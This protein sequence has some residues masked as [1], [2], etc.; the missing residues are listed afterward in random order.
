M[1]RAE[2][3]VRKAVTAPRPELLVVVDNLGAL[4]A[5]H[6]KDMAGM[7]VIDDLARVYADGPA[8]GIRFAASADRTGSVPGPWAALTQQKLL[9]RLADPTEYGYF[10]VPR[11]AVPAFLPGRGIVAGS[12]QVLQ[13]RWYGEDLAA[14][15]AEV[16]AQW[17]KLPRSAP[18]VTALPSRITVA[19]LGAAARVHDDPMW[20]PIGLDDESLQ[21]VGIQLYEQE[22]ALIGGPP[23]SGRSTALCTVAT[24]L[25]AADPALH[26]IGVAVRRSPLREHRGLSAVTTEYAVL[27][28]LIADCGDQPLVL[29]VDDAESVDDPAGVIDQLLRKRRPGTTRHRRRPYRCPS[30]LVRAL[31]PD[32]AGQPQRTVAH[33]GRRPGR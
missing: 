25:R 9:L 8:V 23:R 30:T 20:I 6:D 10:D 14:A 11:R 26:V 33:P 7:T 17:T 1:L 5:D 16:R 29:L 28:R 24:L 15:V 2:L 12:A 4:L 27:A 32:R 13:I 3:D 31:E 22:H 19:Q 21:P 18:A